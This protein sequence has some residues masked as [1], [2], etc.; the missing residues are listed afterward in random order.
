MSRQ[1]RIASQVTRRD[2]LRAGGVVGAGLIVAAQIG[3]AP[4][5]PDATSEPVTTPL[6]PNAFD[7]GANGKTPSHPALLDWLAAE[8]MQPSNSSSVNGFMR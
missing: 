1:S 7:F 6:A 4:K 3:C 5:D 2:F 8:L